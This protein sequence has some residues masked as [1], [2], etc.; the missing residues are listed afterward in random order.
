MIDISEIKAVLPHRYPMLLVDHV[1]MVEPGVSLTAIKTVTCNEPWFQAIPE[2]SGLVEHAYPEV[3]LVESWCQAAGVLA[4]W[5]DRNADVITGEVML[6]GSI[7][8]IKLFRPVFPG[9][10]VEH[11]IRLVKALSDVSIFEGESVVGSSTVLEVGT[12]V[13]A[14]RHAN[15]LRP[16]TAPAGGR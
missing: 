12:V 13:M 5:D 7:T 16:A 11:R 15:A 2:G 6:F 4:A 1:R 10:V 14:R 8:G 9:D 3:L